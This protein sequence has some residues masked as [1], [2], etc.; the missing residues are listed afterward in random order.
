M[1]F[2]PRESIVPEVSLTCVCTRMWVRCAYTGRSPVDTRGHPLKRPRERLRERS[3]VGRVRGPAIRFLSWRALVSAPNGHRNRVTIQ[4][5]A[6]TRLKFNASRNP[7]AH[8]QLLPRY[9]TLLGVQWD[10][11]LLSSQS[12]LRIAEGFNDIV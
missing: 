9:A 3:S 7:G 2:S 1:H 6:V 4:S 10:C 11:R 5:P 12:S 8:V